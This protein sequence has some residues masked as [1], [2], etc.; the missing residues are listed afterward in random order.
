V[1]V[2][3]STSNE[4]NEAENMGL[5]V[6][7]SV[8]DIYFSLDE[9]GF[10]GA[11]V[12][13][14]AGTRSLKSETCCDDIWVTT[15]YIPL[16]IIANTFDAT[17][18]ADLTGVNLS[19]I[20]QDG[21]P[22][23]DQTSAM[24]NL[25]TFAAVDRSTT[26]KLI[27][28]KD[29]YYPDTILVNT[30]NV[31]AEELAVNTELRLKPIPEPPKFTYVIIRFDTIYYDFDKFNIREDASI[32]LDDVA[33]TLLQYPQLVVE[34]GSHTDAI[35]TNSYNDVLAERRTSSAVEYLKEKGVAET[36]LQPK[37]YG[38]LIPVAPN[39]LE[40]GRDYPEGRQLNRRTE[41]RILQGTED[42]NKI[43]VPLSNMDGTT[44][45]IMDS[46]KK[47]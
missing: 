42:G 18:R 2:A 40:N 29:G 37:S 32:T 25:F 34:V 12:S 24:T 10:N 39:T 7:S 9:A 19:L 5:G 3:E 35:G 22:V 46:E 38:E 26:Y 4:F 11:M 33:G 13:N 8:D 21:N 47:K 36:Q 16:D 30:A 6:N 31:N 27:A 43:K 17:T 20:D 41:I 45:S 28:E 15:F 44:G 1:F 14:R 23:D